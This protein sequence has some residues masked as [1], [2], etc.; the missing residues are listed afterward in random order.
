MSRPLIFMMSVVT[1]Q[2]N[3]KR[4]VMKIWYDRFFNPHRSI[5]RQQ[6]YSGSGADTLPNN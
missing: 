1:T 6:N 4:T 2:S 3:I 5:I